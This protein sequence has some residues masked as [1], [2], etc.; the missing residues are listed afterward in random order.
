[1]TKTLQDSLV[2]EDISFPNY[3]RVIKVSDPTVGLEAVI[4][5]HNRSLCKAALGGTRIYPYTSIE[6]CLTDALRLSKGMTYKSAVSESGWGGGKSAIIANPQLGISSDLLHAFAEAVN[7][8]EGTYI[9]AEDVGCG[10]EQVKI[11]AENFLS[12]L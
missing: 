3:E 10:L 11:I 1:M 4:A 12:S 7:R 5:I 6:E 2:L 9:C 8:L